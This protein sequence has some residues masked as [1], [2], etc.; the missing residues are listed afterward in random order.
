METMVINEIRKSY[1]NSNKRF[2]AY[3]YHDSNQNEIDLVILE[4]AML[5]LIEVKKGVSF[6]LADVKA[7]KQLEKSQYKI[8]DSCIICNTEKNY[9]LAENIFVIS[10]NCI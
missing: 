1:L 2:D 9:P 3:Y 4:N 10:V 6:T 5:T 8:G 7:F